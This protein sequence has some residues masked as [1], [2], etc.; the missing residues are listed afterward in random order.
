MAKDGRRLCATWTDPNP[1]PR[2]TRETELTETYPLHVGC[3]WNGNNERI[4]QKHYS[5]V[6]DT[7]FIPAADP[8]IAPDSAQTAQSTAQHAS[9]TEP[10]TQ[11]KTPKNQGSIAVSCGLSKSE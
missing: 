9:R 5:Q 4:A 1:N 3:A 10:R 6:P 8:N 2:A 11:R 7:Y